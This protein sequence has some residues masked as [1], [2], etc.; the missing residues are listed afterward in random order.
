MQYAGYCLKLNTVLFPCDTPAR[1]FIQCIK[2]HSAKLGC[3]YCRCEAE[4]DFD[5]V[6][7]PAYVSDPRTDDAYNNFM[8]NNQISI[9]PL[10]GV[11][12][13][14]QNFPPDYMHL[15]CLGVVRKLFTCYFMTMKGYRF[16]CKLSST[17]LS[18]LNNFIVAH[19][20]FTPR[21]FQR[22]PSSLSNL[23]HFKATEFRCFLL[24]VGPFFFKRFLAVEYYQHFLLLHFSMYVFVSPHFTHLHEHAQRCVEIFVDSV[25]NLFGRQSYSYN[26]HVLL[27]LYSF[28]KLFGPLD[29][30]SSFEFENYLSVLK[31]RVKKTRDIFMQ[32]ISQLTSI[33]AINI[34]SPSKNLF[35]HSDSPNNCALV[36]NKFV[37][38]GNV[39]KNGAVSCHV[40]QFH[41]ALYS[42]PYSSEV[43][44]IG[45]Y[46]KT[47]ER[48]TGH[49]LR[50]AFVF[51]IDNYFLVIPFA[52]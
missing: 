8:E 36:D 48:I 17:M 29:S 37:I 47:Q 28:V 30:F 45:Y 13:L 20:K 52:D 15:V 25:G 4:Y 1:T 27:H 18:E 2:G 42:Y 3:G 26:M 50:K 39:I 10:T 38:V 16:R 19:S 46:V 34:S 24:Y 6:I 5:R 7:F 12:S 23:V 35:F 33:R 40:L 49:A 14:A 32:T 22:R 41:H 21:E 44:Q 51:P 31:R 11:V 43:L 9:S